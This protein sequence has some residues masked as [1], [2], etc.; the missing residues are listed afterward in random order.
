M[1]REVS[2]ML[3]MGDYPTPNLILGPEGDIT[4][5]LTPPW[6]LPRAVPKPLTEEDEQEQAH[7]ASVE[8]MERFCFYCAIL[9]YIVLIGTVIPP[10]VGEHL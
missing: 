8:C 1:N 10:P 6:R 7:L 3:I 2:G 4:D 9:P 5:H